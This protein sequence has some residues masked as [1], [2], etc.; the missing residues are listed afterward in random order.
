M[1]PALTQNRTA[2]AGGPGLLA[3][4]AAFAAG[5]LYAVVSLYWAVGG[6]WLLDTVGSSLTQ[7]GSSASA[8]V[9]LAVWGAV[10]LKVIASVLPLLA[11]GARADRF[12]LSRLRLIRALTWVEAA[13]LTFYGLILTVVGLLVQAG[14]IGT[15]ATADH[16]ALA[17]HAYLWDPWFLVW[18]LLVTAAL[19]RSREPAGCPLRAGGGG[20][21]L[22][23]A[24]GAEGGERVG[25][26]GLGHG[27]QREAHV[28]EDPV[29]RSRPLLEQGQVDRSGHAAH[30]DDRQVRM[31]RVA[32]HQPGRDPQAHI[33]PF[34][35]RRFQVAT[36][37]GCDGFRWHR[38]RSAQ[39]RR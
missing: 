3:A 39:A 36:V 5:L 16:R 26:F 13:I 28:D 25:R 8:L 19:L 30:F 2:A 34:R 24:L 23:V 32:F 31:A 35:L 38:W 11:V 14:L 22:G 1:D 4:W 20:R 37:S 10:A 6:S 18:G 29:A 12:R 7:P 21:L 15:P 9:V 33:V 17:W 27:L